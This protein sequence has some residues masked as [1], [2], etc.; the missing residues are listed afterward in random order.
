MKDLALRD[1]FPRQDALPSRLVVLQQGHWLFTNS[2]WATG[3]T[4]P[5]GATYF[6]MQTNFGTVL[7]NQPNPRISWRLSGV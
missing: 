7:T 5:D 4:Q 1:I 3:V 2:N 6:Y